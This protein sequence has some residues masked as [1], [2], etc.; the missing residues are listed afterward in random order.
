MCCVSQMAGHDP[1]GGG[2]DEQASWWCHKLSLLCQPFVSGILQ[3]SE[4]YSAPHTLG[5]GTWQNTSHE[6]GTGKAALVYNWLGLPFFFTS[7]GRLLPLAP[8]DF[9]WEF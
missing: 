7:L 3:V 6:V 2:G 8:S 9:F 4:R 5:G 1:S